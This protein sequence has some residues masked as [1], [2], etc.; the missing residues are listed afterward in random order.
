MQKNDVFVFPGQGSQNIGMAQ[1]FYRNF[2]SVVRLFEEASDLCSIHFKKLCF[3]GPAEQLALTENLQPALFL[4]EC[5]IITALREHTEAHPL[6]CAGHSLGEYSALFC[7]GSLAFEDGVRLTHQRGQAMQNAVP[8]G[9]GSMC[10][11]LGLSDEHIQMLCLQAQQNTRE[12]VEPANYNA[13]GQVVIA[14]STRALEQAC[15]LIKTDAR[16]D[17]AKTI[18]LA[19]SAPF[20]CSLL[21]PAAAQ[22]KPLLCTTSF[23]SPKYPVLSNVT[24][25]PYASSP[26]IASLLLQQITKPV[27]WTEAMQMITKYEPE[28][29]VEIGPGK[30]L[31]GLMK[32]INRDLKAFQVNT[33]DQMKEVFP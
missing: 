12:V 19:V 2:G 17:G 32:R 24:A 21:E 9:T 16:F 8:L 6:V 15:H 31:S 25:E 26:S 5:A 27:R 28:R 14:G 29:I 23:N 30:V 22:L 11:V 4:T 1:D 7:A 20:H 33:V 3:E 10:A 18:P 13:P